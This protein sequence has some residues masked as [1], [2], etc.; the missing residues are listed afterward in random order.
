M[1]NKLDV[2]ALSEEV[3]RDSQ[4]GKLSRNLLAKGQTLYGKAP[5]FPE[6]LVRTTPDGKKSLGHWHNDEF[7]ETAC[8]LQ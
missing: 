8:L 2:L 6:H 7:V 4:S 5:D 1:T 3:A